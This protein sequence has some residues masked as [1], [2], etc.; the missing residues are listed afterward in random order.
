MSFNGTDRDCLNLILVYLVQVKYS[1]FSAEFRLIILFYCP[2]IEVYVVSVL[3]CIAQGVN[4]PFIELLS[5]YSAA[6]NIWH[7][8]V[9][10]VFFS[11]LASFPA[12]RKKELIIPAKFKTHNGILQE[13]MISLVFY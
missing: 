12:Q 1:F 13:R 8:K 3:A 6:L 9:G 5:N 2:S 10:A 11:L 7:I 4:V